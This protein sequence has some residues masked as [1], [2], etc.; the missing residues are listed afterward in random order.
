[1]KNMLKILIGSILISLLGI[2]VMAQAPNTMMY[3]GRL[4]SAAGNPMFGTI[5]NVTFT[6][7]DDTAS[8]KV[9]LWSEILQL[10]CNEQG[11]FTIE[12][13]LT[14]PL[15][16]TIFNGSK[17]WLGITVDPDPE[18]SPLQ[19]LTSAPYATSSNT[20]GLANRLTPTPGS[21]KVIPTGA[22]NVLD[23]IEIN[24]PSAGYVYVTSQ[25]TVYYQHSTA[26]YTEL[27]FQLAKTRA[28]INYDNYGFGWVGKPTAAPAGL[29][30]TPMTLF[31]VFYEPEA[32]TKK[33]YFNSRVFSGDDNVDHV[34]DL[35]LAAMYFP[36][37][38]GVV[39]YPD[40]G[41]LMNNEDSPAVP[42]MDR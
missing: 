22:A 5:D 35:Q 33:Y 4:T 21:L 32:G 1:M 15:D 29:Y 13:G 42:E 41:G 14:A 40:K 6:I 38:M 20:P 11:V 31:R 17:R 12:L 36:L 37:A 10:Q 39:E 28:T 18:M 7:Y 2:A 27:Y 25:T 23:S 16:N 26:E 8:G 34:Y 19:L 9:A 30:A 24:I 3:Q